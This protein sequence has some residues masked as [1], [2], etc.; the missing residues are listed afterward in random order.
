MAGGSLEL[1]REACLQQALP[2]GRFLLFQFSRHGNISIEGCQRRI[3]E[4]SGSKASSLTVEALIDRVKLRAAVR[5]TLC[6]HRC[7]VLI[8]RWVAFRTSP[9][10]RNHATEA[11]LP[12]IA[13]ERKGENSGARFVL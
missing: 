1:F 8:P 11:P 3:V 2:N 5:N 13:S 6:Q 7:K 10:H 12:V 9:P 4:F